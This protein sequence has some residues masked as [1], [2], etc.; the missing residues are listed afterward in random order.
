V[1]LGANGS[2]TKIKA[3]ITR[4]ILME[5]MEGLWMTLGT[6]LMASW[7]SWLPDMELQTS[8]DAMMIKRWCHSLAAGLH[9]C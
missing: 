2:A 9:Q 5:N 4:H 3:Q 1:D 7:I 6:V 8:S